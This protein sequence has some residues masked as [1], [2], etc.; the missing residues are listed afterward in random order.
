MS[1]DTEKTDFDIKKG[2]FKN[3]DG[4]ALKDIMQNT[5]GNVKED[6]DLLVS[7]YGVMERI[8]VKIISKSVLGIRTTNITNM[9]G[10]ADDVIINSKRKL[11]EFAQTAT[12]FDAKQRMK[13]AKKKAKEGKL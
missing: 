8:E 12:G 3:I 10:I 4:G 9:S 2:C 7:S 5:F 6:G 1:F 13:R 11:N